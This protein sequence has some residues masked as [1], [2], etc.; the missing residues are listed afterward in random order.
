MSK[1]KLTPVKFLKTSSPYSKGEVAGFPED[2][3][4]ALIQKGTVEAY[5]KETTKAQA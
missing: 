3:A 5:K 1:T 4:K 2:K